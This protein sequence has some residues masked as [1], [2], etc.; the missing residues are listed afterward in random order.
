MSLAGERRVGAPFVVAALIVAAAAGALIHR[1][2]SR[3][4]RLCQRV[5]AGLVKGNDAVREAIDWERLMALDVDI[6][7]SY[8][9]LSTPAEQ[10]AYERMFIRGFSE[11]FRQ[12]EATPEAFRGWRRGADGTVSADYPAKQKTLRFRLSIDGKRVQEMGWAS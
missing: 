4:V 3:D 10:V 1:A 5:F 2:W 6:G 7:A 11:G 12:A 9:Q 8:R